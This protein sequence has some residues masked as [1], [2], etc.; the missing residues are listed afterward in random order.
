MKIELVPL[1]ELPTFKF[2]DLEEVTDIDENN[3]LLIERNYSSVKDLTP[4]NEH[5]YKLAEISDI[6]LKKAIDLHISDLSIEES[7]AF[8]GGYALKVNDEYLLFPQC[9]GLLSE[10]ND[11][12]KILDPN[13]EPFYLIECHPSPKFKKVGAQVIIECDPTDED[14][15]PKTQKRNKVDYNSLVSAINKVCSELDELSKKLDRFN[16][17]FNTESISKKMIWEE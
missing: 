12:K 15:Y 11:W 16:S 4:F 1:I 17:E 9:C 8:F 7:C 10:I 2:P 5:Q 6:D 13:F 14:F 3:R